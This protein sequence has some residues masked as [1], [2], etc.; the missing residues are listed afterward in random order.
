MKGLIR[1]AALLF[2]VAVVFPECGSAEQPRG[3]AA[4][5][6]RTADAARWTIRVSEVPKMPP[7]PGVMVPTIAAGGEI[8]RD[9]GVEQPGSLELDK[10]DDANVQAEAGE[11]A[12]LLPTW[13]RGFWVMPPGGLTRF[14][15]PPPGFINPEETLAP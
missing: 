9:V 2:A 10:K 1:Y 8:R 4:A 15:L 13:D 5:N 7:R 3:M 11:G 12:F 14:L 6:A